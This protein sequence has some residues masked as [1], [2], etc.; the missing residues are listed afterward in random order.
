MGLEECGVLDGV[1]ELA[2]EVVHARGKLTKTGGELVVPHDGRD[3]DDETGGGG[4]EGF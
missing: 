2:A 4:D 1:E 3:G